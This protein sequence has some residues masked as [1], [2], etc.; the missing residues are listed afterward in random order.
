MGPY[1]FTIHITPQQGFSFASFETDVP[2]VSTFVVID[3]SN[4]SQENYDALVSH[5]LDIFRPGRATITIMANVTS[6]FTPS[7]PAA[8]SGYYLRDV[9]RQELSRYH[10]VYSRLRK[11]QAE[12]RR[13]SSAALVSPL[14]GMPQ[15]SFWL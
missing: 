6:G 11:G 8:P 12:S 10:I 4:S 7:A 2:M 15:V 5:V 14:L 3:S 13:I 1:F 9:Q